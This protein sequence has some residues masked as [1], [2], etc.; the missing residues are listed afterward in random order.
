MTTI[1][2][3][4]PEES[5]PVMW[6][7]NEQHPSMITQENVLLKLFGRDPRKG[8]DHLFRLYY[9]NLCNHAI[10]FVYTKDIA[11]EIVM[12]VFAN[13]WRKEVFKDITTSYEAYLYQAVRY[14]AY[15][16]LKFE[17]K[18][19]SDLEGAGPLVEQSL[20][21]DLQL[22]YNELANKVEQ[23]IQQL[24]PQSRKAFQLNRIEGKKYSEIAEELGI[25]V[26]AV[27]RL[28]GR[29][30]I[31]LRNGLKRDWLVTLLLA[32]LQLTGLI[33]QVWSFMF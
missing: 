18:R 24:P 27:E 21:P 14:R 4:K 33:E 9:A 10:R 26:S 1:P 32:P 13:F 2:P 19:A 31:K 23:L 25:S 3:K 11:E 15:N 5:N 17:L 28:I 16:Y 22:H 8:C 7:S 6:L 12:E 29:A 20:P 30:L